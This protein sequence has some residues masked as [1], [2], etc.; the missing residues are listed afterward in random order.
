[1]E[2]KQLEQG[3]VLIIILQ[4]TTVLDQGPRAPSKVTQFSQAQINQI[5]AGTQVL[6]S[7]VV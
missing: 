6:A 4:P 2:D 5:S 3:M 1:L 7:P